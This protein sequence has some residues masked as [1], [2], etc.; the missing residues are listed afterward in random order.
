MSFNIGLSGLNAAS[1][2]LSVTG[3]N[4]ANAST[5]GFKESRTEFGDVYT[6]S[7]LGSG[8]AKVGSGVSVADIAQEFT[9]GSISSTDN[10]LDLAIDGTGFFVLSSND[11]LSYTRSGIFS[12]DKD[13]NVVANNGAHLQGFAADENG[14]IGGVLQDLTIEV[15]SQA[16][17]QTELVEGSMNIDASE[18]VLQEIG[19]TV[20]TTGLAVG[21]V[22]TG[23]PES[24]TTTLYPAGQPM[25]GGTPAELAFAT[26]LS[27][28][29]TTG[30]ASITMD[31]DANDGNG[32]QTV[33]LTG[34]AAGSTVA[35]VLS[36]VQSALN[37]TF[38]SQQFVASQG[39]S[40][41]LVI[42]RAGYAAT[43]GSTFTISSTTDWDTTFG[44]NTGVVDGTA[45]ELLFVGN[46]PIS[47]DLSSEPGTS[48]TTRTTST[49]PLEIVSAD[50]GE[51]A[52]LTGDGVYLAQDFSTANGNVLAFTVATGNGSTYGIRISEADWQSAA[53][54]DFTSI[55]ATEL[56]SEINTQI[57]T[58]T[59]TPDVVVSNVGGYLTFDVQAPASAGDYVQLANNQSGS[60][61]MN[62]DDLGFSSSA[63]YDA[64]V[65]PIEANNE[66]TLEVTSDT[67][68]GAGPYTIIIPTGTYASLSDLA[69]EIQDQIDTYIGTS[70]LADKVSVEAVGG[71][72]VFTNLNTGSGEGISIAS[73][74]T[75]PQAVS[76]LGLDSLYEV[77]GVDE[78]D[79][80]NSFR[81]NL[82]VPSPDTEGRSGSVLISL[83]Q[84]INSVQELASAINA[85]LNSQSSDD[86][87]GV[88]AYAAEV[89]PA[90]T[91]AQYQLELR[92]TVEGED[93]T[94]SITNVTASGADLDV[95][96]LYALLQVDASDSTLM[97][98][99]VEGVNN[100]YPETTVTL[101]D[102]DGNETLITIPEY[103][104]ANEIVALLN[105][106]PGITASASTTA[107]ITAAGYNSPTGEMTITLNGQTLTSTTLEGLV[108]EINGYATTSLPGFSAELNTDGDLEISSRTG[109]DINIEIDSTVDT[110]SLVLM[111][112][113]NSGQS[114]LGGSSSADRAATIGGTV[115]IV[116]NEGYTLTD[117]SPSVTGIFGNLDETEFTDYALNVFDP[118]DSSTYN[119]ATS[120]NI[121]DSQ[122]NAHVMTQYFVHE[123]STEAASGN[124]WAMYVTV[125]GENVG[126][127]DYTLDYPANQE[128]TQARFTI[129]FN[130]D[131]TIDEA[132]TGEMYITNW[133]PVDENGDR[134]GALG[135]M[136]V[137]EG[138]LPL[139]TPPNSSNY[140]ITLAGTTLYGSDF[141][142]NRVDQDGYTT[143]RLT[144]LEIDQDG[145]IFAQFSNGQSQTLGQV[146]LADFVNP[147][148]LTPIGDT[149]WAESYASG[150]A[151]IG[152][153]NTASL[154]QIQSAALEDSNVDLSEELVQLIIAQRNFQ[155]NAK[156]I[157]TADQVT[158]AILNI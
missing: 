157:E 152:E 42:E 82:T 144:G 153:P 4:I 10:T 143:G 78:I 56:V 58:L 51:Y 137:L 79:R 118:T 40:G 128:P 149:A 25:T 107:T 138:G 15:S 126:D 129:Y 87:I 142:V 16:P 41:E 133:D 43:D 17:H 5:S 103:S 73:T 102:P 18:P 94:I 28:V 67:G 13:G 31:I 80:T 9:Q 26:D 44:T 36:D 62:L 14:E 117:P 119:H 115:N 86:Y 68:N 83:D 59:T 64:G 96:D 57:A 63:R 112:S 140:Q 135:S 158:Q 81:I 71:Q 132:A 77:S 76:L 37:S 130:Q 74:T 29:A 116:L 49:P 141:A 54:T 156:T 106:E 105:D 6:N 48:T 110:D 120:I 125:D 155:A 27:T 150:S 7:L 101:V 33:T 2:D 38:G 21:V 85:Q 39:T 45:G 53:P 91:P 8:R 131:G 124:E 11:T 84:E 1:T 108:E 34:V 50:P 145:V 100:G 95:A 88:L 111:G 114:V 139:T 92:A 104:E 121:Y 113:E 134:N 147:D 70:G 32:A 99:G 75:E 61:G 12:L 151:T 136:N 109:R 24:T 65:A 148:G 55:S 122:G 93:S 47:I 127:P 30:Y 146:A 46:T 154:G 89:E 52:S 69:S 20:S 60:V 3:N 72:L 22:D 97:V 90:T 23:L 123:P 35:N 98:G 19:S 66:F